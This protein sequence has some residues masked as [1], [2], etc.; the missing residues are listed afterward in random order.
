MNWS[1][2][3]QAAKSKYLASGCANYT[4]GSSSWTGTNNTGAPNNLFGPN[5]YSPDY[6]GTT[7]QWNFPVQSGTYQAVC[8]TSMQRTPED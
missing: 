3:K 7:M 1:S 5:R 6:G 4:S 2:D 8:F